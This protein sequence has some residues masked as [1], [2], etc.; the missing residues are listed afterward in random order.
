MKSSFTMMLT[1]M[2]SELSQTFLLVGIGKCL[3]ELQTHN[4]ELFSYD[5]HV[6]CSLKQMLKEY[7]LN[8]NCEEYLA[9]N[10]LCPAL[11]PLNLISV[12]TLKV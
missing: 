9:V 7:L 6:F 5:F 4:P 1:F 2:L 11:Q 8:S 3:F 12:S 10:L